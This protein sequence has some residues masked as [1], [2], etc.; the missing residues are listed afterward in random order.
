M[1][2]RAPTTTTSE[3]SNSVAVR[4]RVGK[5]SGAAASQEAEAR[6]EAA[7]DDARWRREVVLQ[8]LTETLVEKRL[9][10]ITTRLEKEHAEKGLALFTGQSAH[11][12]A[13]GG[14][15]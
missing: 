1:A 5:P 15:K 10:E 6:S 14:G 11:P 2:K 4:R 9:L 7:R 12:P 3:A 8:V 13:Q